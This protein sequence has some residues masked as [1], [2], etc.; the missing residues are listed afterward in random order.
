MLFPNGLLYYGLTQKRQDVYR[1]AIL[2][3]SDVLW[4]SFVC[5]YIGLLATDICYG[6][7]LLDACQKFSVE[8]Q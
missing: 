7:L 2:V 5:P 1:S 3:L 6:H 8:I 4:K